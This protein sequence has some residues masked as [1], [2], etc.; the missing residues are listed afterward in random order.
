MSRLIKL[1]KWVSIYDAAKQIKIALNEPVDAGDV[2]R[3]ALDGHLAISIHL[4]NE[5]YGRFCPK[6]KGDDIEWKEIP[7]LDRKSTFQ[8]PVGG[9]IWEHQ[10]DM[11]QVT[12]PI[13][14][15]DD[16]LWDLPLIG[17]ERIDVEHKFQ[18]L[19]FGPLPTAISLEGIFIK[20]LDGR[21]FEVQNRSEDKEQFS[22][23]PAK[24]H[25]AGGLPE[26]IEFVVRTDAL[27]D[28]LRR[29]QHD[30]TSSEKPLLARERETLLNIIGVMLEL[31]QSPKPGRTSDTAIIKEMIE[32]YG[33]KAGIKERT[34]QEKFPAAKRS[35]L[36]K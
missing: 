17:G 13:V 30:T 7:A 2:L 19:N 36:S 23:H 9:R 12:T 14:P 21:I 24:F 25:P 1:K 8:I 6:V 11:Y 27:G 32:N 5:A 4:V 18:Q 35:L 33:D 16:G 29:H 31:L 20:S 26:D 15:L 34:L 10:G 28:F 3:L 22:D